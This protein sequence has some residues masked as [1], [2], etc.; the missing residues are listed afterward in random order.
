MFG[1]HHKDYTRNRRLLKKDRHKFKSG[2][3]YQVSLEKEKQLL[4]LK[5][6]S[7]EEFLEYKRRLHERLRRERRLFWLKMLIGILILGGLF[8]WLVSGIY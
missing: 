4:E 2:E 8:Y 5:H 3:K 6:L 1:S 7:D